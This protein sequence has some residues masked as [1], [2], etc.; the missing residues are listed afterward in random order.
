MIALLHYFQLEL[1]ALVVLAALAFGLRRAEPPH[2][3]RAARALGRTAGA[4][5]GAVGPALCA[6]LALAVGAALS[7]L[8]PPVP[9]VHDEF[10]YL[11]AADTFAMGRLT[12]PTPA[13][14]EHFETLHVLVEPSY[15]AKYPPLPG[16]LLAAGQ[17][18]TGRPI[19]G[20]WLASAAAAAAVCWWL[21][22]LVPRRFALLGGALLALQPGFALGWG[23][24]FW[25]G[26]PAVAGSALLL[27]GA[28]RL[29]SRGPG[30]AHGGRVRRPGPAAAAALGFGAAAL[31]ATRPYEGLATAL[32][33]AAWLLAAAGP[34][35]AL[36][37]AAPALL[38]LV[39]AAAALLFY[40]WRVTCDPFL[41][42]YQLHEVRYGV[43]P[44]FFFQQPA[45]VPV[46]PDAT[47]ARFHTEWSMTAWHAQRTLAGWLA[48]KAQALVAAW[49]Y[50]V[51]PLLTLPLVAALLGG[52][53]RVRLAGAAL[54]VQLGAVLLVTWLQPHYLAV[55][56]PLLV[57]L[58]VEGLR[59]LR[60]GFRPAA[61][62]RVV[63]LAFLGLY[64]LCFLGA[65]QRH[66]RAPEASWGAARARVA[67]AVAREPGRH[68]VLVR[69]GPTHDPLVE[70]VY[71]GA[72]LEAERVLFARSLG[73]ARDARLLAQH[74]DRRAWVVHA[75][76][77]EPR[78]RP[79][80]APH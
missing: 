37:R 43:A 78:A 65:A 75:D 49:A 2:A 72:D 45:P 52:G 4:G 19:A 66:V 22:A 30:D 69:Y 73:P 54:A 14:A 24:S 51:G 42:P 70:W 16:L 38:V 79:L 60:A 8:R 33:A 56:V 23:Q 21:Q 31:A 6:A 58:V 7:A 59:R 32:F 27:G 44:A 1:A 9:S 55:G 46:Y 48:F 40:D 76:S 3:R 39:P 67:E 57:L 18:T 71:N 77:P 13:F 80:R 53:R 74:A 10:A 28:A 11:L 12:N 17:L 29:R 61:R 63:F 47:M 41:M 68:L 26:A 5:R 50:L 36:R 35:A 64:V 34:R 15:Q 25:G 20:V 62:G